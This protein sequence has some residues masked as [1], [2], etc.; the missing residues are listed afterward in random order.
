MGS[1]YLAIT[2][3]AAESLAI[4]P[5]EAVIALSLPVAYWLLDVYLVG[6]QAPIERFPLRI[7]ATSILFVLLFGWYYAACASSGRSAPPCR[8]SCWP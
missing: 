7:K 1:G 8:C 5:P 4:R 6:G 2:R 3:Q